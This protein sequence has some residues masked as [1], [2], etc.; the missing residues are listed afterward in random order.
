MTKE[1]YTTNKF[2]SELYKEFEL[3]L[4]NDSFLSKMDMTREAMRNEL[5][6]ERWKDIISSLPQ[7]ELID[8]KQTLKL[9]L[10]TMSKFSDKPDQ[11]W[12][13][14][15]HE[16]V[17]TEIYPDK[18]TFIS[19][20][21]RER[22]KRGAMFYL[23]VLRVFL[24]FEAARNPKPESVDLCFLPNETV[25]H[26]PHY[27]EYLRLKIHAR[28]YFLFEFMKLSREIMP[29]DLFSHVSGVHF[30]SLHVGRQLYEAGV[31]VDISI[32]SGA[33]AMHDI[34]K[35]GCNPDE[36]TRIPHLHYY[37]T[38]VCL[39]S[40][41]LPHISNVASNHSTWDLELENLS[42]EALILIYSDFRVKSSRVDGKEVVKFYSLE[43]A[44][45]V[46]LS[47]LENVD[48]AKE[49]RYR[50][51]YAKLKDFE[52]Y[53]VNLGVRTE[54]D[55]PALGE[56]RKWEVSL[57]HGDQVVEYIKH[58]AVDHNIH[59]MSF[60]SDEREFAGMIEAARSARHWKYVRTYLNIFME[61]CFYL[62]KKQKQMVL[63]FASELL[64][65]REGDIRRE[66]AYLIGYLIAAF[67]E[68]YRK[69]LPK[70]VVLKD[71]SVSAR[72]VWQTYLDT[73][74][75]PRPMQMTEQ[76]QRWMGY[77]IKITLESLWKNT[78]VDEQKQFFRA[79][80]PYYDRTDAEDL[81]VFILLDVLANIPMQLCDNA[82]MERFVNFLYAIS[83]RENVEVRMAALRVVRS[84]ASAF[85]FVPGEIL[86]KMKIAMHNLKC[87]A[88][89]EASDFLAEE[90]EQILAGQ[91]ARPTSFGSVSEV[92]REN[93]KVSTPWIIKSININMLL[94]G[95][96]AGL[97]R[98][99]LHIATHFSNLL[100]VSDRV[101]VRHQ[102]GEGLLK[103]MPLLPLEQRNELIVELTKGLEIGEYEYSKYI[104]QYL[105]PLALHL[106]PQELDEFLKDMESMIESNNHRVASVALDT[107]GHMLSHYD[108]YRQEFGQEESD[109]EYTNR[110]ETLLGMLMKGL[111]NYDQVV[112]QEAFTVLGQLIFADKALPRKSKFQYFDIIYKKFASLME[113]EDDD[114]LSYYTHSA[115][116]N[117]IYRF[118]NEYLLEEPDWKLTVNKKMAFF[119][120]TFDPFSLSHKHIATTIRDLGFEVLL[121]VD[122]FSWSKR[123]QPREM[124]KKIVEMSVAGEK[125]IYLFP[126][127]IP[128]NIANDND[129]AKLK[130]ICPDG[131]IY[132]AVGSDVVTNASSY[133]REPSEN[134][135]H[136]LNHIVFRRM[137]SQDYQLR[138]DKKEE[139]RLKM[140]Q[141][142]LIYLTLPT[143]F[144][145]ISST[146]IRKNIDSNHDIS[147]LID[148]VAQNY[149][150]ENK[151]YLR[152]PQ[153]KGILEAQELEI[154]PEM[155]QKAKGPDSFKARISK[156]LV[157][158]N[159][160]FDVFGD[161][162]VA[163]LLR[164]RASGKIL[165]IEDFV[166]EGE[167]TRLEESVQKLLTE[168]LTDSISQDIAFC[169]YKG[170]PKT[171]GF[172]TIR[173]L[174]RNCG[175]DQMATNEEGEI[176]MTV[177]L[178]NPVI[179]FH[180]TETL[181]KAPF[182][183]RPEILAAAKLAQRRF[184]AG[185]VRLFRGEL[186]IPLDASIVHA[187]LIDCVTQVNQVAR[188]QGKVRKLGQNMC[189]PFGETLM[190]TVVPNTVTKTVHTEKVYS[191]NLDSFDIQESP[192]YSSISDQINVVSSFNRP[193]I[194]LD[195]YLHNGD[196]M[197]KINPILRWAGVDV[198]AIVV[199]LVSAKGRDL[200]KMQGL[201]V[202]SPYFLPNLKA[203]FTESS[204]YP[205]IG[206]D[207]IA[208][209]DGTRLS[210]SS[211]NMIL[212]YAVGKIMKDR[213]IREVYRISKICLEN[214]RRL[215]Q[216]LESAYEEEFERNLTVSNLGEVFNKKCLPDIG[217]DFKFENEI[218]PS[219]YIERD[220]KRLERM[221]GL[222]END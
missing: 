148:R 2:L 23:R 206:G 74:L 37:Y 73:V 3:S 128:I 108:G 26:C 218:A 24:R 63:K 134:S 15:V 220:L 97:V 51:V 11:G 102:A 80:L 46:I 89:F 28:D 18:Q 21:A 185:L 41:G 162:T 13:A 4:L 31:P 116:L 147:A 216:I 81:S 123:T 142:D 68:E 59:I 169:V 62:T 183:K 35:Y 173:R 154:S 25:E 87:R 112:S 201:E 19:P 165:L 42:V 124:R 69:E 40:W 156:R 119:P 192:Y 54:L 186:I 136:S 77:S 132:I 152:E 30:V 217:Y 157:S 214:A 144:E 166:Y 92:L 215:M 56:E 149:I 187:K 83:S 191:Q 48:A 212:P 114:P 130:G 29:F 27:E 72:D 129:I 125:G 120:G 138:N 14:F 94:A 179:L 208:Q 141:G 43:E 104:P 175:F 82:V 91:P 209:E 140:I 47:K 127:N 219:A 182:N 204:Y 145:D 90:T 155:I 88:C 196:R 105:G 211:I 159:Y 55:K 38:D 174:M 202:E 44:F 7:M 34:G 106:H 100:K 1:K 133:D 85:C 36:V 177:D 20:E 197:N 153:F 181:L 160:L 203:W 168:V 118:I 193:V 164:Q 49:H 84:F 111:A 5:Q 126:D 79:L 198:K 207:A 98:E 199:G 113:E 139:E 117:H 188:V 76:Q 221:K 101:T 17:I 195:D 6:K 205:F 184:Q 96:D 52:D 16:F 158:S 65:H 109:Q 95:I 53:M 57:S 86:D 172:D 103:V 78:E 99:P 122:E 70:G 176:I 64:I 110:M 50:K 180:N 8:C 167:R 22:Y 131:Q 163:A 58:K 200:M 32:V 170:S 150:Y 135:I 66:A 194:L 45:D 189:V 210:H 121:A 151:L 9:A 33:A 146:K 161:L 190:R 178:R 12:L 39:Q 137:G 67:D 143:Y 222:I 71:N 60:L 93:L 171:R 115:A 213:P 107:V 61:Y 75:E 10:R